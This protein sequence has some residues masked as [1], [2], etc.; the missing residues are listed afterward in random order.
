MAKEKPQPL[1]P[2][3]E[4]NLEY[5]KSLPKVKAKKDIPKK[6]KTSA[7]SEEF[8]ES[9]LN[10]EA[11]T[12]DAHDTDEREENTQGEEFQ[13]N[14]HDEA[15]EEIEE[16]SPRFSFHIPKF[17]FDSGTLIPLLKKMWIPLTISIIIF[18]GAVYGLSP[19]S[20]V[21]TITVSGNQSET[22]AEIIK[23][24]GI[25]QGDNLY[26]V[27]KDKAQIA[28][29]I[30]S[31]FPR[32]SSVKVEVSFPNKVTF[33]LVEYTPVAYVKQKNVTYLALGNGYI[34][35]D[36]KIS[37]QTEKIPMLEN[38]S[39]KEAQEFIA[40]YNSL[41]PTLQKLMGTVTK[42]PTLATPDFIAISMSDGNQVRVPLSQISQKMPYYPS[43]AKQL[44]PPQVIDME[45][46][47]YAKAPD[48]YQADLDAESQSI[49]DS[50]STSISAS[51]QKKATEEANKALG[52]S[53]SSTTQNP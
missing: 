18:I 52:I 42:T 41:N 32:V 51:A 45:A 53:T 35:K 16:S 17:N 26:S 28:N 7:S 1:S 27:R 12:I 38:F 3:Q 39:D 48:A 44:T 36:K 24:S 19:L 34:I 10:E 4:K 30:Q 5:Q 23:A 22:T 43:I 14:S 8:L 6:E 9:D 31:K 11:Q 37:K 46:S 50:I 2:W 29:M 49:S 13:A 33:Q 20:N 40:A 15:E 47:F 25:Q 21:G